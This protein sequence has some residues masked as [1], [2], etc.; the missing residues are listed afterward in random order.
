M[1]IAFWTCK[2]EWHFYFLF[3]KVL[4]KVTPRLLKETEINVLIFFLLINW[5]RI[6]AM[7][8]Q[9]HSFLM[10]SLNRWVFL[11]YKIYYKSALTM[12]NVS[13]LRFLYQ[14]RFH[15]YIHYIAWKFIRAFALWNIC[16]KLLLLKSF[17]SKYMRLWHI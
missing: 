13:F 7:I 1:K 15:V 2:N 4:L 11:E 10:S 16:L 3:S 6:Q 14:I 12:K 5:P 8:H 17:E 9:N